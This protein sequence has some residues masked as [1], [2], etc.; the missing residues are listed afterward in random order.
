MD[1]SRNFLKSLNFLDELLLL[2]E[3]SG[4]SLEAIEIAKLRGG[5]LLEA[6]LLGKA[7]RFNEVSMLILWYVF[8]NS[9]W[10][11]RSRGWPLKHFPQRDEII[12]KTKSF[13]KKESE[14]KEI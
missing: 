1:S 7:G 6:D 2:E 9:M 12:V 3:E 10:A 4:N 8:S 13:A 11:S 14:L 5:I